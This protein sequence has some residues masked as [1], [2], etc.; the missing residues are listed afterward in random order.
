M[1]GSARARR[2]QTAI[3]MLFILGIILTGIVVIVP[4]Y[5][6]E[7]GESLLVA[8]VRDA[9]SQAAVY[10]EAGVISDTPG[11]EDLNDIIQGYTEYRSVGF[12]LVGV[13]LVS[14]SSERV[15][16]AVKFTHNFSPE[17]SR[18][19]GIAR[20]IGEFLKNHLKDVNGFYLKD[21]HLYY[22]GRLVE[23]KIAVGETLE[24]IS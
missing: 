22:G 14:E 9:A 10:I 3:E 2:G 8:A 13:S 17:P 15:T 21:G 11:Y 20:K 12:R 16:I 7:S 23:F 1:S 18:D 5:T 4:L 19:S 6:Q 24:V